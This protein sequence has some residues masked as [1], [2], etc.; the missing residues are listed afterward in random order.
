VPRILVVEQTVNMPIADAY[1]DLKAHLKEQGCKTL[2]ET[3]PSNLTVKQGSL[4][5]VTPRSAKKIV[6]CSLNQTAGET[7]IC[8]SSKLSRDWVNLTVAG[9]ALAVVV[10]GLC[11][12]MSAD[13]TVFLGTAQPNTWS[14]IASTGDYIDYPR[15]EAFINLTNLLAIFLSAIIA[16]EAAIAFYARSRIDQ[17][18]KSVLSAS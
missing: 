17:F 15:A 11:L 5:G 13:L 7:K 2:S 9:T 16:A 14:W 6:T 10:V 18:A 12:W 8:C 3:P 4:W 1:N